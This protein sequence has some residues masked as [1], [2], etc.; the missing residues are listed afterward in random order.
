MEQ[1][2][3]RLTLDFGD[4]FKKGLSFNDIKGSFKI[5]QGKAYTSD[6]LVDAI[7]AQ[8]TIGGETDLITRRLD[9]SVGVVPKSA[10][11]VPIAGTIVSRIAGTITRAVTDDYKTG[12]FFGSKYQVTGRWGDI[13]VK[14]MHDQDGIF[15]KTWTGLTDFF[16]IKPESATE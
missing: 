9:Y 7:P 16:L 8:I 11:A 1:W 14:S 3:K 5:N 4:L 15:K 13:K 2:V 6:L 12:Y 10:G